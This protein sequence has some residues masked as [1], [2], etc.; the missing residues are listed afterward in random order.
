MGVP[1][2]S[3]ASRES[4][5]RDPSKAQYPFNSWDVGMFLLVADE[6]EKTRYVSAFQSEQYAP[7]RAKGRLVTRN[8]AKY[9][10][11]EQDEIFGGHR[12]G[13]GI[14]FEAH[15]EVAEEKSPETRLV[16]AADAK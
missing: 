3:K 10:T 6:A 15:P 13:Y 16:K 7:A 12:T 2:P 4:A 14:W 1:R 9:S 5:G 8:I 11:A